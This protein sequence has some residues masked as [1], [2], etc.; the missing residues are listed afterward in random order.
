MNA[1][2]VYVSRLRNLLADAGT[3]VK[4]HT[5]RGVSYL[6]ADERV[7][8]TSRAGS[9][10]ATCSRLRDALELQRPAASSYRHAAACAKAA[11]SCCKPDRQAGP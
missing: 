6:L 2:E 4:T 1:V 11:A 7:I 5:V 3:T 8:E 10:G 9:A